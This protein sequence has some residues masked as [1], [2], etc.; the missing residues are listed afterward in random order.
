[1]PHLK[2]VTMVEEP[3]WQH[4]RILQAETDLEIVLEGTIIHVRIVGATP[5][6]VRLRHALGGASEFF[7]GRWDQAVPAE[8]KPKK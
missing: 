7:L 6:A 5:R 4:S 1:M 3:S 2:Q 8:D